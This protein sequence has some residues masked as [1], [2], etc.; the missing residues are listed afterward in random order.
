MITNATP[1]AIP[2]TLA[3]LLLASLWMVCARAEEKFCLAIIPDSQQEVLKPSDDRLQKRLEW[4]VVNRET[5]N[6]K[7]VLH[8]GDLMNWDTPDHIQYERASAAFGVLDRAG[9][10][11]ALALGN[12]DTAATTVGGS[13]APGKVNVNLRNTT[14][15]NAYFPSARFKAL[16]AVYEAG[17]IDNAYHTFSAGG[18]DWLVLNL[19]LWA[20]TGAVS[21]AKTVLQSPPSHNVIVLTHSHLNAKSAIVQT[22]GGYGDNSPQYVFDHLLKEHANVRLVFSGHVGSHGYR[23]DQGVNGNPIHQFLQCY[24]DNAANPVRLFEFDTRQGTIRTRVHCPSTGQDK[25][26]GSELTISEVNWVA[27]GS[28]AHAGAAGPEAKG[29]GPTLAPSIDPLF[30]CE[31]TD[32]SKLKL[33]VAQKGDRYFLSNVADYSPP[34]R[35]VF[36]FVD[37]DF[38]GDQKQPK[39]LRDVEVEPN[40]LYLVHLYELSKPRPLTDFWCEDD[41]RKAC[42]V[43]FLW[44]AGQGVRQTVREAPDTTGVLAEI[45]EDPAQFRFRAGDRLPLFTEMLP[46]FQ[47]PTNKVFILGRYAQNLTFSN[48]FRHGVTHVA[49]V[50]AD[51]DKLPTTRRAVTMGGFLNEGIGSKPNPNEKNDHISPTEKAFM[52]CSL[53][54]VTNRAAAASFAEYFFLDEEFWH[55]DYQPATIERLGVFLQEIRRRNPLCKPSDFWS[56]APPYRKWQPPDGMRWSAAFPVLAEHYS[57]PAKAMQVSHRAVTRQVTVGGRKTSLAELFGTVCVTTYF[58]QLFGYEDELRQFRFDYTFPSWIHYSRVNRRLAFNRGKPEIW[59]GMGILEGNYR[60][61]S[62]AFRTRTT[63]PAGV[64]TWKERLPV[65]PNVTE[66][67]ALFGLLEGD[68]AYLWDSFFTTAP[69]PDAMFW[70]VKYS[71]DYKDSRGSWQPDV[72]G[73]PPGRSSIPGTHCLGHSPVYYALAAWKYAQIA[74]ILEGGR[75]LDF[76]YSLDDGKTWYVPPANGSTMCDVARDRRPIVTGAVKDR[77]IAVV[78]FDPY[79]GVGDTTPILLRCGESRFRIDLFGKRVRVYRGELKAR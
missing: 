17:K 50:G 11:Y 27:A 10:P 67:L 69:G 13:A 26:D 4:L 1:R 72:P 51:F 39:P 49:G 43:A 32:E 15:F 30:W 36:Y 77:Q 46:P 54:H 20:R 48:M 41:P 74:D 14:T 53:A 76:E 7:M 63:N 60:H 24:H 28:P 75:R 73:T 37:W 68:G 3:G 66:Q 31:S 29:A 55:D 2:A 71:S 78:A 34:E 57:D 56:G 62:I 12:H 45:R 5:L 58:D 16:G 59:F 8:V 52:E 38:I 21:W 18:L 22:P 61:P 44:V 35:N 23:K 40:R 47:L 42:D 25:K 64:V 9:L 6:L 65:A 70:Q 19:E 33:H 79:Q